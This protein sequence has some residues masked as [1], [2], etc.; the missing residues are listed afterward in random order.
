[1]KVDHR[2][3]ISDNLTFRFNSF[4][5]HT[6]DQTFLLFPVPALYRDDFAKMRNGL[7]REVHTFSPHL[8]NEFT[9]SVIRQRY[10]CPGF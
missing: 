1:M 10:D 8:I 4:D 7:I 6:V 2:F 5:H 9:A 3:S